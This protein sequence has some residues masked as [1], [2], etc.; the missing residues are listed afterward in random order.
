MKFDTKDEYKINSYEVVNNI[1]VASVTSAVFEN[2]KYKPS[3]TTVTLRKLD[4]KL[5]RGNFGVGV[6]FDKELTS[7]AQKLLR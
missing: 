2:G 3:T 6:C 4:N 5:Y 1:L 7:L